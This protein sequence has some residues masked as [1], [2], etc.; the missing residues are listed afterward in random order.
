M[1]PEGWRPLDFK[2]IVG[3]YL[4]FYAVGGWWIEFDTIAEHVC[5]PNHQQITPSVQQSKRDS[6]VFTND[7]QNTVPLLFHRCLPRAVIGQF[8]HGAQCGI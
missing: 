3:F 7:A 5:S 1:L 4:R 6:L 8:S 2:I